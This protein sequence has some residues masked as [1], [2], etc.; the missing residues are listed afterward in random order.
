[1]EQ[2]LPVRTEG[3]FQAREGSQRGFQIIGQ[4]KNAYILCQTEEALLLVD[5]H[6]AHERIVYE[7]LRQSFRETVPEVQPFLIP[8]KIELSLQEGQ[9]VEAH[10]ET[11]GRLGLEIEHF[12]G[13]TFLLKAIP[14]VLINASWDQCLLEVVQAIQDGANPSTEDGMD[15]MLILM[16]CHGAIRAGTRMSHEEMSRL[17]QQLE[18]MAIP[19]N[20]PHGRPI[21]RKIT[22]YEIEKMFKRL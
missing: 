13:T 4:L 11:L 1:M 8:Q 21:Y 9:I 5:Q 19:T 15:T 10:L 22:Y 16:A 20:C 7:T 17:L 3:L 18:A 2:A 12:G 14:A 6:A